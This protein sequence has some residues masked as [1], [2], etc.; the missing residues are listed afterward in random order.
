MAELW[1]ERGFVVKV[2]SNDHP[3]PHVHVRKGRGDAVVY[4]GDDDSMP[5]ELHKYFGMSEAD[6]TIAFQIVCANITKALTEWRRI[7]EPDQNG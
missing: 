7:H 4:L 6:A 2:Y 5:P 1:R 3:P